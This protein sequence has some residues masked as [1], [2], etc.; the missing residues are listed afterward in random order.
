MN[1]PANSYSHL[2]S[3]GIVGVREDLTDMIYDISPMDT[4]FT[5][6][7]GRGKSKQQ[8]HEWQMDALE[9][10][11]SAASPNANID[12]DD[13]TNDATELTQRLNNR[14]QI[15]DKVAQ[16][17]G[18]AEV[19]VK[20]GRD[21][22][23]N[24]VMARRMRALKRDVEAEACQNGPL[25]LGTSSAA[26]RAAGFETW[27]YTNADRATAGTAGVATAGL[28]STVKQPNA[29]A[30][31][32]DGTQRD[33][34]ET[35]FKN[36]LALAFAAGGKSPLVIAGPVNKQKIDGFA[37]NATPM[38]DASKNVRVASFGVYKSAFGTHKI[39]PS[40]F[41]RERSVLVVDPEYAKLSYLRGYRTTPL[42]ITGDSRRKQLLVDWTL[43]MC[44]PDAHGIVADLTTT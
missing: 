4:I 44:N 21:S 31:P 36:V 2:P 1:T 18:R 8:M 14:C 26:P 10:P 16:V 27:I 5:N 22:E 3:G 35:M 6:S 43:E 33:I 19:V 25:V 13:A 9:T 29:S 37:G 42:A 32:T 28:S 17:T 41:N 39:V 24:R 7:I 30:Q 20:A 12:G 38:I 23:M 15:G 11:S 40:L 34:T